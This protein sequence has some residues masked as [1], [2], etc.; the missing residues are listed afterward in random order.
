MIKGFIFSVPDV[1]LQKCSDKRWINFCQ[2]L[3]GSNGVECL[4]MSEAHCL[5][6]CPA[7]SAASG[8]WG[9]GLP[10]ATGLFSYLRVNNTFIFG[11]QHLWFEV[12]RGNNLRSQSPPWAA[13]AHDTPLCPTH[14]CISILILSSA[15]SPPICMSDGYSGT[16]VLVCLLLL[17]VTVRVTPCSSVRRLSLSLSP[18]PFFTWLYRLFISIVSAI[19]PPSRHWAGHF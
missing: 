3:L 4:G 16:A 11:G 5:I 1:S 10:L 12:G 13:T 6:K 8:V 19:S 15:G 7:G 17:H 9:D 2:A 18:H 14:S